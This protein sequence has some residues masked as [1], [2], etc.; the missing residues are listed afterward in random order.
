MKRIIF[1]FVAIS[2]MLT[3]ALF[4][5]CS[6]NDANNLVLNTLLTNDLGTVDVYASHSSITTD[7]ELVDT[8]LVTNPYAESWIFFS[9]DNPFAGWHHDCRVIFVNSANGSYTISSV[10]IY[11]KYLS[12]DYDEISMVTRPEPV[13]IGG[14]GFT[15]DETKDQSENNYALIIVAIDDAKNWYNTSLIYNV[16]IQSYYYQKQNII[17]LYSWD[18]NSTATPNYNNLDG[19]ENPENDIDGPAIADNVLQVIDEMRGEVPNPVYTESE[20]DYKLFKAVPL[21]ITH[22]KHLCSSK[23][24]KNE[25]N[26]LQISKNSF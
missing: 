16:L 24:A 10:G 13:E 21:G 20:Q 8:N 6:R 14:I 2:L 7:L 23:S 17:V 11:P 19:T 25:Y 15:P 5:Q 4:A 9:D 22:S 1:L 18:G 3:N 26:T 12:S